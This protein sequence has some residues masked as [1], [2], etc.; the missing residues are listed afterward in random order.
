MFIALDT[1]SSHQE[2][3]AYLLLASTKAQI[4]NIDPKTKCPQ[5]SMKF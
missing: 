4:F 5:F 3:E 2:L 1:P